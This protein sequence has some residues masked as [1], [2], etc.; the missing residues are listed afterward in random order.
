MCA[1]KFPLVSMGGRAE[2]LACADPVA[3]IPIGASRNFIRWGVGV[4]GPTDKGLWTNTREKTSFFPLAL[5]NNQ[6]PIMRAQRG[7]VYNYS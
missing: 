5:R 1:E 2:G 3:R 6:L 7:F 4:G